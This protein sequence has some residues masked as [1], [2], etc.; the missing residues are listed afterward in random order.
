MRFSSKPSGKS[1][2]VLAVGASALLLYGCS[3]QADPPKPPTPIAIDVLTPRAAFTD[4]VAI[5]TRLKLDGRGAEVIKAA[6]PSHIVT[7]R[8][9]V[10][11]DAQ[12]PWHTHH[13]PVFVTVVQGE[14]TSLSS[15]DCVGRR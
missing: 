9:T 1:A 6:D 10:Q 14:M 11:P 8:I 12:F 3:A 13:G 5:Q 7:A 15:K 4:D 2:I